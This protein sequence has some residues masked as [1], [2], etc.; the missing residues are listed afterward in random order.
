MCRVVGC[1]C[2]G[3][4]PSGGVTV[5]FHV[6]DCRCAGVTCGG[7]TAIFCFVAGGV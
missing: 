1:R 7:V 2:A 5:M 4:V 6:A 3:S